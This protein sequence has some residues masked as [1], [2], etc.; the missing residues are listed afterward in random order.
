MCK[1]TSTRCDK[2]YFDD[3]FID[4]DVYLDTV[5]P[6]LKSHSINGPNEILLS[7]DCSDFLDINSSMFHLVPQNSSPNNC[8]VNGANIVLLFENP[9]PVNEPFE[10]YVSGLSDT[11]GNSLPDTTIHLYLQKHAPFDVIINEVMVDPEPSV[12]LPL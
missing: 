7:Y 3:F 9:F 10:L 5:A 12:Q 2:F 6:K 1:Y 4:G 8:L 11:A